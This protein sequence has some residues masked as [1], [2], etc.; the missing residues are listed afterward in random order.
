MTWS[1]AYD[2]RKLELFIDGRLCDEYLAQDPLRTGNTEPCLIG[3]ESVGGHVKTGFRGLIDHAVL[4][5]RALTDS[6]I[7]H[8]SGTATLQYPDIYRE[9]YRPQYHFSAR[10]HWIN[11][12]N[13]L[14]F[15]QGEYHLYFQ[16]MP[17]SRPGALKDWGHAVSTDLASISTGR[18]QPN[19]FSP[20]G[21]EIRLILRLS[22]PLILGGPGT[23]SSVSRAA[24]L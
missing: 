23:D 6:E 2:G 24:I 17:P 8:L 20:R 14:V 5:N 4:W 13:G 22:R 3:A 15:Y 21:C 10:R 9:T 19:V 12:P 1:C 18:R 11:D 16:Y 7:A